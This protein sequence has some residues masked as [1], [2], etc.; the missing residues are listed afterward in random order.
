MPVHRRVTPSIKFAET[1]LH[2]WVERGTVRVKCLAQEHNT[3]TLPK[4]RA[5]IARS[6][7][8]RTN[9]KA[10]TTRNWAKGISNY[11]RTFSILKQDKACLCWLPVHWPAEETGKLWPLPCTRCHPLHCGRRIKHLVWPPWKVSCFCPV[12]ERSIV[13][14]STCTAADVETYANHA[15]KLHA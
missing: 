6:R 12:K 13:E 5:W 3:T 9:H 2:T 11:N 7:V 8:L 15:Q 1:H 10:L 4:A 14:L